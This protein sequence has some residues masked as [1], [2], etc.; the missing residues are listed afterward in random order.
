VVEVLA[1]QPGE[2][3]SFDTVHG[4]VSQTLQQQSYI[5]ALR[6]YLQ[7]LAADAQIAGVEI[8]RA[9]SALVQ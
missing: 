5:A 2:A 3:L 6:Q 7:L 8:D 4:A 1:R 9:E